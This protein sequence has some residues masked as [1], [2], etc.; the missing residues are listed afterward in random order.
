[1]GKVVSIER[2]TLVTV[3]AAVSATG[4]IVPPLMASSNV[5]FKHHMLNGAL[6]GSI[7][8]ANLGG[9]S[10]ERIFYDYLLYFIQHTVASRNNKILVIFHN[11]ESHCTD[12]II[13]LVRDNG[14][15]LVT[16]PPHTSHKLQPLDITIFGPFKTYYNGAVDFLGSSVTD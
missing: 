12:R 16:L 10:N 13:T 5:N 6:S 15:V 9:W 4:N 7:G 2:R 3:T 8:R 14:L 1:M 11:H